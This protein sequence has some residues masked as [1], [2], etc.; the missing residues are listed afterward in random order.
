MSANPCQ[1]CGHKGYEHHVGF[2]WCGI[3]SCTCTGFVDEARPPADTCPS[4][5]AL[6]AQLAQAGHDRDRATTLFAEAQ[7]E[8][9]EARGNLHQEIAAKLRVEDERDEARAEVQHVSRVEA[10]RWRE[11]NDVTSALSAATLR[12]ER[13]ERELADQRYEVARL[14]DLY[15]STE[16]TL[17]ADLRAVADR[18][19]AT[20]QD[21]D[22]WRR[23]AEENERN[24]A[25]F[26]ERAERAEAEVE[27]LRSFTCWLQDG[28]IAE[29]ATCYDQGA[30]QIDDAVLERL[31]KEPPTVISDQCG[32]C[33]RALA[34][35][36]VVWL[37][38]VAYC[39]H[40]CAGNGYI[41]R[42]R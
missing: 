10:A 17:S 38:G 19:A 24:C 36:P 40:S 34:G 25:T 35:Y 39:D 4:C 31:R 2:Q 5:A 29:V 23:R 16:R 6:R 9:D 30:K 7:R 26:V 8:R 1:R 28:G 15:G 18:L 3:G 12:A 33:A 20:S 27:R 42:H 37:E 21:R 11:L 32:N 22:V 13:A 14:S 41:A